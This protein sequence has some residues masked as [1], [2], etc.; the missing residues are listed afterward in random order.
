MLG[1][2]FPI[3]TTLI[4]AKG[5]GGGVT[6][7]KITYSRRPRTEEVT[8]HCCHICSCTHSYIE[9]ILNSLQKSK[10]QKTTF[11][12]SLYVL[13]KSR[14][15]SIDFRV[16]DFAFKTQNAPCVSRFRRV[17]FSDRFQFA[18]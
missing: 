6:N 18:F 10:L 1:E 11:N 8:L 17:L 2:T 7:K 15:S 4:G 5:G 13:Y 9:L 14:L 16:C 3:N 12:S